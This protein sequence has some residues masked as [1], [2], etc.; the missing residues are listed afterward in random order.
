MASIINPVKNKGWVVS[1]SGLTITGKVKKYF[2]YEELLDVNEDPPF[3]ALVVDASG[4][5]TVN[6]GSALYMSDIDGETG[7]ISWIKLYET[8]LMDRDLGIIFKWHA[9]VDKPISSVEEID[10]AVHKKHRHSNFELL[11]ALSVSMG[12]ELLYHGN[13]IATTQH[14][15]QY[16]TTQVFQEFI[17]TYNEQYEQLAL[18]LQELENVQSAKFPIIT[19]TPSGSE[20]E[21]F[22]MSIGKWYVIDNTTL[23]G[24]L[25]ISPSNHSNILLD[26]TEG[27]TATLYHPSLPDGKKVIAASG[28][29]RLW[30]SAVYN[31]WLI[32]GS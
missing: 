17:A 28:S 5:E 7:D 4:D 12:G 13:T 15:S 30:F 32:L 10:D 11:G 22:P 25:P 26:L 8:E 9:I 29:F 23:H 21:L 2:T 6:S 19:T 31:K 20:E 1:A 27:S 24:S 14:L 16:L 3:L 18:R